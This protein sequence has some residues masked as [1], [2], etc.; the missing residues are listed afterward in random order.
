[1]V[2]EGVRK[3][4]GGDEDGFVEN[5]LAKHWHVASQFLYEDTSKDGQHGESST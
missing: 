5:H 3:W 4:G 2:G 1:M